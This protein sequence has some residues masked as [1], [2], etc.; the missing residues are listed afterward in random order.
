M[1][2]IT[3]AQVMVLTWTLVGVVMMGLITLFFAEN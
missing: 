3:E 2:T 1:L